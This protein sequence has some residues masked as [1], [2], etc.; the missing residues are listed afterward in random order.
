MFTFL[1]NLGGRVMPEISIVIPCF[2][3]FSLMDKCLSSLENQTYKDFEIIII[4]D[5]STDDSYNQLLEYSNKSKLNM[6]LYK[7]EYNIGPGPSRNLGIK[8]A[9]GNYITFLDSDDYLS[10]NCLELIINLLHVHDSDCLI[11]DY[12]IKKGDINI[13]RASI[14]KK[15]SGIISKSDAIVYTAGGTWCKI[16]KTKLIQ[17]NN[18]YFADLIRSEDM[19]FTKCAISV[20]NNIFYYNYP[21]Y[22]YVM[23]PQSLMHNQELLDEKNAMRA[24]DIVE[25]YIKDDYY[26]ETEAIF[27]KEYVYSTTL[28]LVKKKASKEKIKNHIKDTFKMYPNW[29]NNEHIINYPLHI[30]LSIWFIKHNLFDFLYVILYIK[31]K[32][33]R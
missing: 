8:A 28:T 14:S 32:L 20:C 29:P 10:I 11:F 7:N 18:I 24:F 16:Y 15:I 3:S 2:N 17:E 27:I 19:P 6:K 31:E 5:C 30:K 4:D 23:H 26:Q 9:N 33:Q 21:L 1:I 22:Y 12:F 25:N 13:K